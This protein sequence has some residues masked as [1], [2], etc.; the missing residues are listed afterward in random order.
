INPTHGVGQQDMGTLLDNGHDDQYLLR[1][2]PVQSGRPTQPTTSSPTGMVHHPSMLPTDRSTMGPSSHRSFCDAQEQPNS[3]FHELEVRPT[4]SSPE[5]STSRV[6]RMGSPLHMSSLEPD[7]SDSGASSTVSS[8]G[9]RHNTELARC[10]MVSNSTGHDQPATTNALPTRR[11]SR[12][13][14]RARDPI[15]EPDMELERMERQRRINMRKRGLNETTVNLIRDATTEIIKR[16]RYRGVQRQFLEW[17]K[18]KHDFFTPNLVAV[19]NFLAESFQSLH[20]KAT[21]VDT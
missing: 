19:M 15:E 18:N 14:K 3:S 8:P 7:S 6:E 1:S 12:L 17:C 4:G 20:W 10:D 11:S 2:I 9:H 21:T 5:C 13:L 16:G